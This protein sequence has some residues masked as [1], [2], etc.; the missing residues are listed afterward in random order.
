MGNKIIELDAND[1]EFFEDII[2]FL[3]EDRGGPRYCDGTCIESFEVE[4]LEKGNKRY[5]VTF[6]ERRF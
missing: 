4:H 6:G 3:K 5:T 2:D 1:C